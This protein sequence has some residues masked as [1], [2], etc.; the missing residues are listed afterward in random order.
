MNP[1]GN[2]RNERN[3]KKAYGGWLGS[4]TLKSTSRYILIA[5]TGSSAFGVDYGRILL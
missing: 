5:H 4:E 2:G 3:Q 1:C